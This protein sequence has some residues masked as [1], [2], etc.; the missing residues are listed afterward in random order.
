MVVHAENLC[1]YWVLSPGCPVGFLLSFLL[2]DTDHIASPLL[3]RAKQWGEEGFLFQCV[4]FILLVTLKIK[5]KAQP[6]DSNTETQEH[7]HQY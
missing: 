4:G 2:W 5:E 3:F 7:P 1:L 6:E